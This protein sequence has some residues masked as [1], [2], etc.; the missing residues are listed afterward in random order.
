MLC[1]E[2]LGTCESQLAPMRPAD[3]VTTSVFVFR[4]GGVQRCL[5][6][7][8]RCVA[9]RKQ[10]GCLLLRISLYS[11]WWHLGRLLE[12]GLHNASPGLQPAHTMMQRPPLFVFVVW[13]LSIL[14][15]RAVASLQQVTRDRLMKQYEEQYPQYGFG[16]HKGYGVP[17]HMDA[18]RR[19]GPCPIHRR[20]FEP[21]KSMTGWVRRP[22]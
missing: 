8:W 14:P 18:V 1:Q 15:C 11:S 2:E 4:D 22:Q 6:S 12:V 17:A 19:H 7:S 10:A 13:L 20:S 3:S 16:Q 21:I 9:G 5:S